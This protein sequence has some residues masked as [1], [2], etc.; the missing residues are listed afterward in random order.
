MDKIT[1]IGLISSYKRN[2]IIF[3]NELE[4]NLGENWSLTKTENESC[5]V[6][7]IVKKNECLHGYVELKCRKNLK[8]HTTLMIGYTK[9]CQI[10]LNYENTILCWYCV[11]S[12]TIYSCKF[13]K[14]L[15]NCVDGFCNGSRVF[16]IPKSKCIIGMDKLIS[17]IRRDS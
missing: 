11:D 10:H 12:K 5:N 1:K 8:N 17:L 14:D 13:N 16:Y 2:E 6:D 7:F 15:L 3:L 4:N 9:L